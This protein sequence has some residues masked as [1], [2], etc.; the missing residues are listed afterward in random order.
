MFLKW[1]KSFCF[2]LQ[3]QSYSFFPF[4]TNNPN[5]FSLKKVKITFDYFIDSFSSVN[6]VR[7]ICEF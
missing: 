3:V 7:N 1:S 4:D 5:F 2:T 6:S